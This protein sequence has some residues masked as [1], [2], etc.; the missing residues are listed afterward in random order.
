[1]YSSPQG[2]MLNQE[3]T[4]EQKS[5]GGQYSEGVYWEEPESGNGW[6]REEA[7]GLEACQ[8]AE[9]RSPRR[10]QRGRPR[11]AM[12]EKEADQSQK[13]MSCHS[14]THRMRSQKRVISSEFLWEPWVQAAR[15]A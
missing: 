2:K 10:T 5:R 12:S 15:V 6:G 7:P 11:R 4:Q 3:L 1:M 14:A 9:A 8:Q 13:V